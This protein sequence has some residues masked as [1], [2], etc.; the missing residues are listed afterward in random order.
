MPP[1]TCTSKQKIDPPPAGTIVTV[2]SAWEV[3]GRAFMRS[4]C[5]EA[6]PL[7]PLLHAYTAQGRP[8]L[9]DLHQLPGL[10]PRFASV[11]SATVKFLFADFLDAASD[12]D[13][14][15]ALERFY[16]AVVSPPL[17]LDTLRRRAGFVRHGVM[18]LLHGKGPFPNGSRRV[19][20]PAARITLPAWARPS[21]PGSFRGRP[22]PATPAGRRP[23]ALG[24]IGWGWSGPPPATALPRST[25]AFSPFTAASAPPGRTCRPC[26]ST[27]SSPCWRSC[28]GETSLR[29][30]RC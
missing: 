5:R 3:G 19:C 9:A 28:L 30:R 12:A 7:I 2:P 11:L 21:G 13:L 27:I 6:L 29:E 24:S 16:T 10:G 4:S 20:P 17:H 22:P 14:R 8:S 25:P 23:S 26:T 1:C 15:D 18:H